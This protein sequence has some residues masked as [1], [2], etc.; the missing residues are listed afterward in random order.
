MDHK[1]TISDTALA[2][3][4]DRNEIPQAVLWGVRGAILCGADDVRTFLEGLARCPSIDDTRALAAAVLK[5]LPIVPL[6]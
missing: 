5:S 3:L 1:R 2:N 6:I 4:F